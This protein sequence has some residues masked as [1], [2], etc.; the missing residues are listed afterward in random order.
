MNKYLLPNDEKF[1]SFIKKKYAKYIIPKTKNS[2][3]DICFPKKYTLQIPQM[4][5][6]EYINPDTPND[7]ILVVHKIGSGKTC[8]SIR[9]AE[10]WKNKRKII[11]LV[12]A[13]LKGNYYN[14]LRSLCAE[15]EYIS[16]AERKLLKELSSKS[17]E[18]KKIIEKSNKK[19]HQY[20]EIYSYNKFVELYTEK[21]ISLKNKVLIVDEVQN[22]VSEGGTF[23]NTLNSAIK[24]AKTKKNN[25]RT[26]LLSATP[27]FDK[28]HEIALT[29]NLLNL[30]KELPTGRE[31]EKMFIEKIKKNGKTYYQAK[32]MDYFKKLI[33][34]KVSY[35]R[36]APPYVF[37][38][39]KKHYV[40]CQMESF[41]YRSYLT[42]AFAEA[43]SITYKAKQKMF[44]DVEI[45]DL[46]NNFY[47]G[48]RIISNI[49]FPN[50]NISKE[51]FESLNTQNITK[52]LKSYSIKF[53]KIINKINQCSG[54]TFVYSNFKEYGGIKSFAKIL[55]GLGYKSYDSHGP[56][57]KRFAIWSGDIKASLREEIRNVY[58]KKENYNGSQIKIILGTPSMKEGVSLL[59]VRQI[60]IMEPY[61][62]E[63]RLDQIIGRGVRFCSH[64]ELNKEDR[65]V[66]VYIYI[67]MHDD[68]T[69]TVDQ[70]IFNLAKQKSLLISQFEQALKEAA[71][72]CE[73]FKNANVYSKDEDYVCQV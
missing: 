34:G 16:P 36:G 72:D 66:D 26:I 8:T 6:P 24:K 33:K 48:T 60:H 2:F 31:F 61:W 67:A 18:Y 27:I 58:N 63:S 43:E 52:K 25:L 62:N 11:V 12:P 38:E 30:D 5:L 55:E 54:P 44:E 56:G 22:M 39:M 37:P 69:Q 49:A 68:I 64:K 15:N 65:I 9:I 21:K 47:L 23:Y 3:T 57:K 32:N 46:P 17:E 20:Y 59:K 19:I 7:S 35:F 14:E 51:G 41:Q 13:A 28:P 70:Y 40:K 29:L 71:V 42:V 10:E 4:F 73:L 50:L 1:G 45:M 53:Y